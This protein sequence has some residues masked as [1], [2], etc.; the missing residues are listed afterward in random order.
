M[1]KTT[2]KQVNVRHFA[3][4]ICSIAGLLS[5]I[6]LMLGIGMISGCAD[7]DAIAYAESA[8]ADQRG[9]YEHMPSNVRML[10]E[11]DDRQTGITLNKS[12]ILY[13]IHLTKSNK[14]SFARATLSKIGYETDSD[15]WRNRKYA[16]ATARGLFTYKFATYFSLDGISGLLYN[17]AYLTSVPNKMLSALRGSDGVGGYVRDLFELLIGAIAAFI[18][19]F[20]ALLVNT[21]CHPLQTVANLTLGLFGFGEGW[22]TYVLHTNIIAS[23]WDLIWGAIIY[24]IWQIFVFWM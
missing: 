19:I 23:L 20:A 24:P 7:K 18:G 6:V 9:S 17:L 21:I 15:A 16:L 10:Y 13:F 5:V 1:N 14:D 12:D 11:Y 4:R 8:V 2:I 22:L 3:K